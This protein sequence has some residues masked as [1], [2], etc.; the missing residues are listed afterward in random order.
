MI[1]EPAATICLEEHKY[2]TCIV[3]AN[4]KLLNIN[5]R[6]PPFLIL[7]HRCQS[8]WLQ[9]TTRLKMEGCCLHHRIITLQLVLRIGDI[10][11]EMHILV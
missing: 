6:V 5:M 2:I 8:T 10:R 3:C 11:T 9:S 1:F 4:L 7:R